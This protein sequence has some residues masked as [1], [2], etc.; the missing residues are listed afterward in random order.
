MCIHPPPH[1]P[2]QS[3]L[4]ASDTLFCYDFLEL[5]ERAVQMKWEEYAK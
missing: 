3:A 2:R 1:A 4:A 5:L